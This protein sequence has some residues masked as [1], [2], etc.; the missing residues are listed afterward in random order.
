MNWD[1][2][3]IGGRRCAAILES[4]RRFQAEGTARVKF[5][6]QEYPMTVQNSKNPVRMEHSEQGRQR[7]GVRSEVL[8]VGEGVHTRTCGVWR[9]V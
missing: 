9:G 7:R 6:R 5:L 3:G 2:N 4:G 8:A 1:L